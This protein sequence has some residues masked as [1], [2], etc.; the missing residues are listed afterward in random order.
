MKTWTILGVLSL[1]ISAAAEAP[2]EDPDK[3]YWNLAEICSLDSADYW[4]GPFDPED[5]RVSPDGVEG[6]GCIV[7]RLDIEPD[8]FVR[9]E[10]NFVADCHDG[11]QNMLAMG[12]VDEDFSACRTIRF[13]YRTDV[14]NMAGLTFRVYDRE[15]GWLEWAVPQAGDAGEW[16]TVTLEMPADYWPKFNIHRT[17]G[18]VWEV[19]AGEEAVYGDLWLDHVELLR[20]EMEGLKGSV[21]RPAMVDPARPVSPPPIE[22]PHGSKPFH[23]VMNMTGEIGLAMAKHEVDLA[24]ERFSQAVAVFEGIPNLEYFFMPEAWWIHVT[25]TPEEIAAGT[26]PDPVKWQEK[27]VSTYRTFATYCEE[28]E[29][30]FYA[31]ICPSGDHRPLIPPRAIEAAIEAAPNYCRGSLMGEFSIE[32]NPGMDEVIEVLRILK[33]HNLKMLYFNQNTY[34]LG[35]MLPP[36]NEFRKRVL[37]PEFKDVFVP[38]G[39]Y[40]IPAGQGVSYASLV[41]LWEGGLV[42]DW[43]MSTQ[44][45]QYANMNWGG[46]SDQ[47]GSMWLRI[48][49]ATAAMG[50]RYIEI[51][52][53]WAFDGEN[54][55]GQVVHFKQWAHNLR[56]VGRRRAQVD[57]D[58]DPSD[59]MRALQLMV[60]M[61]QS[62]AIV[63]AA[64]PEKVVS[65]SPA[66]FQVN[67]DHSDG[68]DVWGLFH[69]AIDEWFYDPCCPNYT[70][71]S[72][73]VP[74]QDAFSY[75]YGSNHFYDQS[76]PLTE[77]GL[78]SILPDEAAPPEGS[79]IIETNGGKV[80]V[81]GEWEG[82]EA[83]RSAIIAAFEEGAAELPFTAA[84]CTFSSIEVGQGDYLLVLLDPEE[85]F[86]TGVD[87]AI[88]VNLP[89]GWTAADG[90]TGAPLPAV[91]GSIAVQIP[92]AGFQL[93]R[94][95]NKE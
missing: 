26:H 82:P 17:G 5:I 42:S 9:I 74:P 11:F 31:A 43:G 58:L 13:H 47:P 71:M 67:L 25:A 27:I 35:I 90:L 88:K 61:A 72:A 56:W 78:V 68:W 28:N 77:H 53:K 4:T 6:S 18:F 8:R 21:H 40:V 92:P 62:G 76:F 69:R 19:S 91:E 12:M 46:T 14:V 50:G 86:P 36:G 60:R 63:P 94:V 15:G 54:V 79:E 89:G 84:G 81:E 34:W 3:Q 2:Q 10:K 30:P 65:I 20:E 45:W 33:R 87:T 52:P 22:A 64:R 75:L 29:I 1:A 32:S 49:L 73:Q 44:S 48:F 24:L 66:H 7:A 57:I 95:R 23:F 51:E 83:A 39:E 55:P 85:R 93:V 59:P 37:A 41:G 70:E 38:M 80:L 16:R